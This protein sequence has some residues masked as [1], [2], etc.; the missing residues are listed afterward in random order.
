M[1]SYGV[2][3]SGDSAASI[4]NTN[5]FISCGKSP[6]C[7]IS[8]NYSQ[9]LSGVTVKSVTKSS[10][11]KPLLKWKAVDNAYGYKIY[12]SYSKNGTYRQIV[13][14]KD[15]RLIF[16][17]KSA[18]S[19]NTYYYKVCAYYRVSSTAVICQPSSSYGFTL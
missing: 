8:K 4:K 1:Q 19:G 5:S 12:R 6:L 15:G 9:D 16:E 7:I 10:A 11:S 17:D 14:V 3:I 18:R 13:T 2:H